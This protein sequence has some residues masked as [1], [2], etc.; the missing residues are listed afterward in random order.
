[1]RSTVQAIWPIFDA[2]NSMS[3]DRQE[4]LQPDGL[5]DTVIANMGL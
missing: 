5:A 3:I 1:M 2:D 4:F